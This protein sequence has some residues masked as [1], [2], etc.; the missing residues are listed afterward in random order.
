MHPARSISAR[1]RRRGFT[2]LEAT[3]SV[4]IIGVIAGACLPVVNAMADNALAAQRT[5]D[6][7]EGAAFAMERAIRLIRDCPGGPASTG[8]AIALPSQVQFTDGRGLR[9]DGTNLLLRDTAGAE[10]VLA[11]DVREFELGYLASDGVTNTQSAP[12]QTDRVAIRILVGDL[13]LRCAA[14][15]RVRMVSP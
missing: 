14:F 10:A 13:E 9:L 8:I 15:P 7:A 11:R 4:V 5:R 3:V 12:A 6:S 2:L 1:S